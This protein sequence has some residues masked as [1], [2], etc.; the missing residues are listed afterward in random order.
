MTIF[1]ILGIVE[2]IPYELMQKVEGVDIPKFQQLSDIYKQA[3]P[4]I[5]ALKPLESQ[6]QQIWESLQPD[7]D[8]LLAALKPAQG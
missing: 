4:H 5:D 8:A 6:A 2:R 3:K 1:D 7:V